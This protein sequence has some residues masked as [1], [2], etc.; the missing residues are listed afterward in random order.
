MLRGKT[1]YTK[2]KR[3]WVRPS[4]WSRCATQA[5][6]LLWKAVGAPNVGGAR[7]SEKWKI[8]C[9]SRGSLE[10]A[11]ASLTLE[12]TPHRK[13]PDLICW[14]LQCHIMQHP[15]LYLIQGGCW[16]HY[17][18]KYKGCRSF[19]YSSQIGSLMCKDQDWCNIQVTNFTCLLPRD[20]MN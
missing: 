14:Q 9:L 16:G 15:V 1:G 13:A 17:H 19:Y 11:K 10:K 2:A 8:Q 20:S 18:S 4:A 12:D 5:P 3:K 7:C 6:L